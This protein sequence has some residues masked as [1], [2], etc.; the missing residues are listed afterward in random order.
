MTSS[1][2][3]NVSY[4][5]SYRNH[6]CISIC[7]ILT[8]QTQ[9][10]KSFFKHIY[11]IYIWAKAQLFTDTFS[12]NSCVKFS[13]SGLQHFCMKTREACMCCVSLLIFSHTVFPETLCIA[14]SLVVLLPAAQKTTQRIHQRLL[15]QNLN[16][17]QSE[18]LNV[19]HLFL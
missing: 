3:L 19:K 15:Q 8:I 16:E 7:D 18:L 6:V 12:P 9:T 13:A 1:V 14:S 4:K 10:K 2:L 11:F 5:Y 17:K